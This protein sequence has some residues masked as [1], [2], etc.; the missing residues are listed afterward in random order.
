MIV[1]PIFYFLTSTI[2]F[3]WRLRG[4][5]QRQRALGWPA[6]DATLPPGAIT[7]PPA[8][9]DMFRNVTYYQAALSEPYVFY[10]RG[11]RYFGRQLAPNRRVVTEDEAQALL[12]RMGPKRRYRI[13]FNPDNP[14]EN[15]LT[16]GYDRARYWEL[17]LYA[18]IGTGLPFTVLAG[19]LGWL[20]LWLSGSLV[21]LLLLYVPIFV[22]ML[23]Y[24]FND[25]RPL[26]RLLVEVGR[27]DD[28]LA[29]LG[30]LPV[31]RLADTS[32]INRKKI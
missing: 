24:C 23:Y 1:L 28:G 22:M 27:E 13:R 29:D 3:G 14:T 17:G 30:G 32:R 18:A 4:A 6:A 19:R 21:V 9:K 11:E 20:G 5:L 7:F 16:L 25:E 10:A 8:R 2:L 26:G 31:A 15:Y 12:K